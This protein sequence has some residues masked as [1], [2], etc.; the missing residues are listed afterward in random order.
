MSKNIE[1]KGV[2][3]LWAADYRD[4]PIAG[5][6]RYDGRD[7]W[8]EAE[9][10]NWDNP[11][12]DRRCF[13]YALSDEELEDEHE[14]HRLFRKHVGTHTDYDPSG[15]R[16]IGALRPRSEW[17]KFYDEHERRPPRDYTARPPVGWF[18]LDE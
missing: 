17:S 2:E 9:N 8:F 4:G 16:D 13:L 7:H 12:A 6:A 10:F 15:A 18:V 1:L 3:L 11:P 14:W 5:L